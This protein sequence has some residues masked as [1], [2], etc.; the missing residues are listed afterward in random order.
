MRKV[1]A[2]GGLLTS[3]NRKNGSELD[4]EHRPLQFPIYPE[5]AILKG[6]TTAN[7][8]KEAYG[9]FTYKLLWAPFCFPL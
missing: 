1:M 5:S 2:Q 9:K 8:L 4:D 7:K 3:F 6:Q